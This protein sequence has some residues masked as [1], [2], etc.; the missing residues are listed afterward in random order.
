MTCEG[1]NDGEEY[2]GIKAAM[3]VLMFT[4]EE[5]WDIMKILAALLHLGNVKYSGKISYYSRTRSSAPT[6]IEHKFYKSIS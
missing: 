6:P 2:I 4:D 5:I 3:K 1:R